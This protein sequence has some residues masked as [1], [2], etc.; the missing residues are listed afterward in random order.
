M[1]DDRGFIMS[2]D[3]MQPEKTSRRETKSSDIT[4]MFI[5]METW[6]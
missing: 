4:T 2:A 3:L 5:N 1:K 6:F